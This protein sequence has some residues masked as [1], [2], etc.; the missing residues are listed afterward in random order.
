MSSAP[1]TGTRETGFSVLIFAQAAV[2]CFSMGKFFALFP[3]FI[4][5]PPDFS[6]EVTGPAYDPIFTLASF[7]KEGARL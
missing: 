2:E 5:F 1:G 7:D 6:L 4:T 3:R